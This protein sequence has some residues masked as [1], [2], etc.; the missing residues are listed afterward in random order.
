M[1]RRALNSLPWGLAHARLL[2]TTFTP[3]WL[4]ECLE[5][6]FGDRLGAKGGP[7]TFFWLRD[8]DGLSCLWSLMSS[9]LKER[10]NNF[11]RTMSTRNSKMTFCNFAVEA[12]LSVT[13]LQSNTL[14][15]SVERWA[16]FYSFDNKMTSHP[17]AV[18]KLFSLW[19]GTQRSLTWPCIIQ[20]KPMPGYI[21]LPI[22]VAMGDLAL[23]VGGQIATRTKEN[24]I[25]RF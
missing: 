14:S 20:S 25:S 18:L 21:L 13:W 3:E 6:H 24:N 1:W 10:R 19:H 11:L 9:N 17:Y 2:K 8:T 16:L 4:P 23:R 15:K 12:T 5:G 7:S 22:L